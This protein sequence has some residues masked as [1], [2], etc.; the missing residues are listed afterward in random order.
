MYVKLNDKGTIFQDTSANQTVSG[1]VPVKVRATNRVKSALKNNILTEVKDSEAKAQIKEAQ[2]KKDE[3]RKERTTS[4]SQ[5]LTESATK[6]VE[7]QAENER[8][9]QENAEQSKK[10]EAKADS[11]D[12]SN[13]NMELSNLKKMKRADLEKLATDLG[14]DGSDTE[15]YSTISILA[16]A[17]YE[18]EGK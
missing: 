4:D 12:N 9:K 7:L 11:T 6:M 10:L 2:G 8:L 18:A 5:K 1:N 16:E 13:S 14:I 17:V 15:K 3:A